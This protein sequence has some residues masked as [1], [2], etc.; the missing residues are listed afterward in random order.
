MGLLLY[1]QRFSLYDGGVKSI[2]ELPLQDWMRCDAA[3][4]VMRVLN[5]GD[6]ARA[7]FVGGCVRNGLLGE[8]VDD[9]DI[10]TVH[11][12]DAVQGL[13]KAAGIKTIPTGIE[14]GTVTAVTDGREFQITTLRKD[15][16]TDGR[17]AVVA[18]TDDWATDA[19]RRDFTMNTLLADIDGHVYDPLGTG[20]ADLQARRV[21]FVGEAL[22]RIKEDALRILRFFRFHAVYGRGKIDADGL[23]AC[24]KGAGLIEGLSKER[25]TQEFFKILIADQAADTLY[26]MFEN[27]VLSVFSESDIEVLKRLSDLQI[28]YDARDLSARLF[29]LEDVGELSGHFILS[30]ALKKDMKDVGKVLAEYAEGKRVVFD[31]DFDLAK[32]CKEGDLG[33]S[34]GTQEAVF[35]L[36]EEKGVKMAMYYHGRE[37]AL[38]ALLIYTARGDGQGGEEHNKKGA[39]IAPLVDVIR[40]WDIPVFPLTGEDVMRFLGLRA[41]KEVGGF[42]GKLEQEWFRALL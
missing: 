15:V 30:N 23:A 11:T 26:K 42:L 12:P 10:A 5:N 40:S 16:E 9:V 41:G 18:F 17:Y 35:Y 2:A 14:H 20:Y 21:V 25:V 31:P 13:L 34:N 37:T 39:D 38:Q 32:F 4:K 27:N 24:R 22:E 3:Q 8:S 33:G 28:S 6:E 7:L 19:A 36:N 1:W 29:V